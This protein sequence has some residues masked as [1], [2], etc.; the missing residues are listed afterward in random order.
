MISPIARRILGL[1]PEPNIAGAALGQINY[2]IPYQREKTT[3]AF[4][5][6][7]NHQTLG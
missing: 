2:Q 7:I 4:D 6:K 5:V 3:D 1:I